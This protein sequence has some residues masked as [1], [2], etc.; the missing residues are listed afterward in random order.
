MLYKE[1][2]YV[3]T[4]VKDVRLE[5]ERELLTLLINEPEYIEKLSIIPKYIKDTS[6]SRLFSYTIE[7]YK[8]YKVINPNFIYEKHNDFDIELF[9]DIMNDVFIPEKNILQQFNLYQNKIIEFYKKDIIKDLQTKLD[10]NDINYEEFI[11]K[12]KALDEINV[13][14]SSANMLKIED[15]DYKKSE[16]IEYIKSNII[17]LD[18]TIKGFA[19]SQ[20]SVWSGSNGGA[21]STFLNQLAIESVEQ[22]YNVA[23]YSG[24]LTSKRILNWIMQ[25]CAGKNNMAFNNRENYF[26]V[27]NP[28]KDKICN[29]LNNKMFI[30]NNSNGN[31]VRQVLDSLVDSIKKYNIK[32]IIFD[33][34][35]SVNLN[36][37]GDSKY[38]VQSQLVQE[39]S[40]IAKD[41]NVHIHFVCHPRKSTSFLRKVDISGSADLTNIADNVFIMH[42]VN[43]DFIVRTK[44]MFKW[45]EDNIIY[46]YTNVCEVCKNRELGVEDFF[47][48]MY[49]EKES[50][51]LK[52]YR[53]ETKEY[54]W[55][56]R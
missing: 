11:K 33:N 55:N 43:N 10:K 41:Y 25:Q 27:D 44:E 46:Q 23:I 48:G 36:S 28:T 4:F 8:E 56:D 34:L 47:V 13:T 6:I 5:N 15:I 19:L 26:Y 3:E 54:G 38:D 49:F 9:M 35:M 17:K 12:I 7:C 21:K 32:V 2:K 16:Q 30:Y 18:E 24:E 1:V 39:L 31:K 52:N 37:M 14:A 45:K 22:G 53:E 51:R 20:L 50:K 42:R 29:W 40:K